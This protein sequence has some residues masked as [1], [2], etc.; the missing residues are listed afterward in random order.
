MATFDYKT[1]KETLDTAARPTRR[2]WRPK[3]VAECDGGGAGGS[4]GGAAGGGDAGAAAGAVGADAGAVSVAADNAISNT[5]VLGKCDHSHGGYLGPGCF[6]IP[7][8]CAVPFH[9]WEIGNGGS[10]RKKTKRGKDKKTPYEVGMK[11]VYDMLK[12]GDGPAVSLEEVE[13]VPRRL[14]KNRL[15]RIAS[16]IKTMD[17]VSKVEAKFEKDGAKRAAQM[18]SKFAK[19]KQAFIDIGEFLKDVCKGDYKASWFTISLLAVAAVYVLCPIDLIPDAIPVVGWL[20]DATVIMWVCAA[21]KDEF[22]TWRAWKASSPSD[23]SAKQQAISTEDDSSPSEILVERKM[24][25][26]ELEDFYDSLWLGELEFDF[27]KKDGSRRHARGTLNPDLMP[28]R[29]EM[30]RI[31]DQQGVDLDELEDRLKM[32][33]DYMPYFWDLENNGYRQFH[34]SRFEGITKSTPM[35]SDD[36][37]S[38]D[39]ENGVKCWIDDVRPA[40]DSSYRVFKSTNDFMDLVDEIGWEKIALVDIDHDAGDYEKDGGDYIKCLDYLE[41][42]EAKDMK[43]KLHSA[44]PVGVKNMR[45]IIKK[46]EKNG[47]SEVK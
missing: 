32:R 33:R 26:A 12:E 30:K 25:R 5:E 34:V 14:M 29:A 18:P 47:W 2:D 41:F 35:A 23:G 43:I 21:L 20:D 46:N 36:L 45:A 3:K 27:I 1:L 42:I 4:G 19:A 13:K 37:I 10:K 8:R 16:A 24:T 40:P 15:K 11:V 7:S 38:E 39:I 28:S 22:A 31:Y 6:H 9:R 44:N 17:D